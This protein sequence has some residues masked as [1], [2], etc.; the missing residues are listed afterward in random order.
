MNNAKAGAQQGTA[1]Y[2]LAIA[3]NMQ[4]DNAL[5]RGKLLI[6]AKK[7]DADTELIH[8][9]AER[10][11]AGIHHD[12]ISSATDI[13]N[14]RTNHIAAAHKAHTD[15]IQAIDNLHTNRVGALAGAHHD[16][17]A[18]F[19]KRV[20]GMMA[21]R[22]P[23][24]QPGSRRINERPGVVRGNADFVS[25]KAAPIWTRSMIG[26]IHVLEKC[27][28]AGTISPVVCSRATLC[29]VCDGRATQIRSPVQ[30]LRDNPRSA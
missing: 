19:Q 11:R 1:A 7:A 4:H 20:A 14:A 2:D 27:I 12:S 13:L 30:Q 28:C 29:G 3:Q 21:A 9:K 22:Q 23:P 17:A 5:Q 25:R 6:D 26:G 15:N 18:A 16:L 24:V 10:E 8:A